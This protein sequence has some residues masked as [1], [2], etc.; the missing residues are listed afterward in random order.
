MYQINSNWTPSEEENNGIITDIYELIN[1]KLL[2][3]KDQTNCPDEFIHKF[4][5]EIQKEWHPS[6]C[7]SIVRSSKKYFKNQSL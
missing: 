2:Y 5:G 4:V 7:K 6:S 3:L 1:A